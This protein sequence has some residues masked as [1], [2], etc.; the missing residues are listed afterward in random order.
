MLLA[1]TVRLVAFVLGA[2]LYTFLSVLFARKNRVAL[3]ALIAAAVWNAAGAVAIFHRAV[4]G[5]ENAL[6]LAIVA[7][8][9]TAALALIPPLVLHAAFQWAGLRTRAVLLAYLSIPLIWWTPW[10]AIAFALAAAV[11]LWGARQRERRRFLTAFAAALIVVPFTAPLGALAPALVLIW[12]IYRYNQFGLFISPRLGFALQMG[13]VF[14]LYLLLVRRLAG[15]AQ[16]EF[17]AFG[18]LVELALIFAAAMIWLPLYG[19]MSRFLSR[20]ATLYAT[21]SRRIIDDAARILDLEKRVQFLAEEVGRAF[22]LRRVLLIYEGDPQLAGRYGPPGDEDPAAFNYRF[23]LRYED[24]GA[25]TL[26]IDTSPR[27]YLAEDEPVLLALSAQISHSLE[28]GRLINERIGLERLATLGRAA[29]TLAHEVKNPLSSI[30]TLTQLLREDP[31]VE[32][33][34]SR[35]LGFIVSEADRLNRTVEQL[36]SFTRAAPPLEDE[37]N[38]SELLAGLLPRERALERSIEPELLLRR[39]S[40]EALRQVVLNLVLNAIEASPPGAPVAL[41][42]R[43]ASG[44]IVISVTDRGLGIPPDIRD[45]IFEPFFTTRQKGTG[46]GLAIVR[47]NVQQMRGSIEIESPVADGRGARVTIT[48]PC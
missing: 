43:A 41:V 1:L 33:R 19:W 31:D 35:D 23:P 7:Q 9:S 27:L 29:A 8:V 26:L 14:A 17:E 46:L 39:A 11:C 34:Y 48:L 32:A 24:R 37:V 30:K 38:V 4:A 36:L 18:P 15:F 10:F 21:F 12:F 6:L 44:R 13:V 45:R 3:A 25:G 42:A 40:S 47:K 20:R 16:E 5:R 28:T 2:A 22:R